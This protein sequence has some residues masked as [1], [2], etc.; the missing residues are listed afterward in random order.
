MSVAG[1][2]GEL[3]Q[4]AKHGQ[5][6]LCAENAFQLGQI[7]DL[8]MA[9]VMAKVLAKERRIEGSGSHNVIVLTPCIG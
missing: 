4:F 6:G 9:K 2:I 3:L 7:S 5:I 1:Q 8:V